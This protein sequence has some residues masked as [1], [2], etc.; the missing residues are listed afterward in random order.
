MLSIT[1]EGTYFA[2]SA[3]RKTAMNNENERQDDSRII[4]LYFARDEQAITETDR[5]YG[6]FCLRLSLS[7]LE[8][9]RDAEECVNDT[10]LKTWNSIP[11]NRPHSLRAYIGRIVRNLSLNRYKAN[12]AKCRNRDLELSLE[13][14]RD[15]IPMRDEEAS[16]LPALMNQFLGGLSQEERALFCNRYWHGQAVKVIAKT[17]GLTPKAVTMRLSRT[18][19]KLKVF[20]NE[21]GY[22]L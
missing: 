11:P 4:D 2:Y 10:Y 19:E 6:G 16:A 3:E 8:D 14:L 5:R 21:R 1:S 15:C 18:R 9:K 7:I 12:R 20:L 17:L 13:E 22:R